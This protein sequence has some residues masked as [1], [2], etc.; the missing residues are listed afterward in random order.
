MALTIEQVR[1][2][3][4]EFILTP[5]GII[6]GAILEAT[7]IMGDD[8]GR[9]LGQD[10]YYMAKLYLVAH[11]VTVAEGTTNGDPS[12]MA[13]IKRSEVD[14]VKLEYAISSMDVFGLDE[15]LNTTAYGKRYIMYRRMCFSGWYVA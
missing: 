11:L 3:F 15:E 4:P 12:V 9:W 5:D 10:T 8:V 1:Q 13:P 6:E 14:D 2:K 7:I